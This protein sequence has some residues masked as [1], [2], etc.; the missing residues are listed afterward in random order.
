MDFLKEKERVPMQSSLTA[1]LEQMR[2]RSLSEFEKGEYFE[3]LVKVFLEEDTL[4]GQDYDKVWLFKDWAFER[5]LPITDTEIDF[6][7]RHADGSGF[8]AI[9]YYTTVGWLRVP[10]GDLGADSDR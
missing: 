7:A 5:G 10:E 4:Q 6:V 9:P 1:V 2:L 8:C 3:K